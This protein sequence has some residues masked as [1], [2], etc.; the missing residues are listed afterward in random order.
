MKMSKKN[1][2]H[3]VWE[4]QRARYILQNM[5]NCEDFEEVVALCQELESDLE[6]LESEIDPNGET[7]S[8]WKDKL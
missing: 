1:K 5:E 8:R 2:H 4:L 3:I 6:G 7:P